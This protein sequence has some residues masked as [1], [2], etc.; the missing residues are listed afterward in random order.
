MHVSR[1]PIICVGLVYFHWCAASETNLEEAPAPLV[2]FSMEDVH[3]LVCNSSGRPRRHEHEKQC[4]PVSWI[5]FKNTY[6]HEC[7]SRASLRKTQRRRRICPT[8][9]N[10]VNG[11]KM[12]SALCSRWY[13]ASNKDAYTSCTPNALYTT[14]R[15]A[16]RWES[17]KNFRSTMITLQIPL[18]SDR[19]YCFCKLEIDE[20][21]TYCSLRR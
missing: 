14:Q 17:G 20:I 19:L 8:V 16:G 11:G 12:P 6:I 2:T 10:T 1:K 4:R 21:F 9:T 13:C 15:I 3:R 18:W 7:F 5:A